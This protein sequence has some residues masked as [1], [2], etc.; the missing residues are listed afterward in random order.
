MFVT[1]YTTISLLAGSVYAHSV[2][3]AVIGTGGPQGIG[4]GVDANNFRNCFSVVPC[5][6]DSPIMRDAELA[7]NNVGGC[8]RTQGGGMIDTSTVLEQHIEQK[9][10][11]EVARGSEITVQMHQV[12]GDGAGPYLCQ[13]D[14]TGTANSATF[15]PVQVLKDVPG[16]AGLNSVVQTSYDMKLKLPDDLDCVGG[17]NGR[18]CVVRCRNAAFAGSFGGC[19]GV[20]QRDN[21]GRKDFSPDSVKT[22]AKIEA[23]NKQQIETQAQLKA[24]KLDSAVG[25]V[26]PGI[27]LREA[28]GMMQAAPGDRIPKGAKVEKVTAAYVPVNVAAN[29]RP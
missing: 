24:M 1:A 18:S 14:P 13:I 2:I 20:I 12:N 19:F 15:R 22:R 10:L 7:T 25:M 8:G 9:L 29:V 5:Q 17:S 26:T 3:S 28:D 4:F 21:E 23:V 6:S 11:P 16:V 27:A